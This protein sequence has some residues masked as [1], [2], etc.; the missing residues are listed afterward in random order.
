LNNIYSK[1]KLLAEFE[2]QTNITRFDTTNVAVGA[3]DDKTWAMIQTMFRKSTKKPE[4]NE[5]VIK[6]YVAMVNSVVKN[7][8]DGRRVG[9]RKLN[10]RVYDLNV[11]KIR[12]S[13]ELD[14]VTMSLS[15]PLKNYDRTV[16]DHI[17]LQFP[18]FEVDEFENVIFGE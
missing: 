8:Y 17:R 6:E 13:F 7:L 12:T 9:E 1:I 18:E 15:N 14:Y 4:S 16:M 3:I 10:K 5:N 11:D 2:Q